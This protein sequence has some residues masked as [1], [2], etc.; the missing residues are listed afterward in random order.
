MFLPAA[1]ARNAVQRSHEH[2]LGP[3]PVPGMRRGQ[4]TNDPE[5]FPSTKIYNP[6]WPGAGFKK[7]QRIHV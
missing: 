4:S 2:F 1:P 3:S 7:L 5:A 6:E